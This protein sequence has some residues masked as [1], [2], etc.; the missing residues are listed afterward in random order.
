MAPLGQAAPDQVSPSAKFLVAATADGVYGS[1][2]YPGSGMAVARTFEK[3]LL[4]HARSVTVLPVQGDVEAAIL[5]ASELGCA[6]LVFPRIV[7]WEDRATEWS[8]RRDK[9][10]LIVRVMDVGSGRC[11]RDAEISGKSSW[12]TFGGDHPQ[13]LLSEPIQEFVATLFR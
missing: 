7:H 12:F 11:L 9:L 3:A 4:R 6:V 1:Q 2:T 13:D 10:S 5:Q 8:G